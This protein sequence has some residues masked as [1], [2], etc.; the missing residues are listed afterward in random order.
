[1]KVLVTGA[2][3]FIGKALVSKLQREGHAVIAWV[4]DTEAAK[5]AL[6]AEVELVSGAELE[7]A[8]A[9]AGGVVNL[10]GEPI[11]GRWTA[12]KKARVTESR[13]ALTKRVAAATSGAQAGPQGGPQV[14]VS[15]SAVGYY[16]DRG[17]E[18]LTEESSPG[19]GFLT[20]VCVAW[21][22]AAKSVESRGVRLVRPRIGVVMGPGGGALD[23]MMTPF[24][25]GAGGR[26]GS[27]Q[28]FVPWVH[29]DDVLG[30]LVT[31]LTDERYRG[32]LNLAAPEP[33]RN[34]ELTEA[35]AKA[36]HRP[37][38]VPVP[39]FAIKVALGEA[40]TMVLGSTRATPARAMALGFQFAWTDLRVAL[41]AIV[42]AS[43]TAGAG[44]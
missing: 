30:L 9:R 29:L 44:G 21:E 3:G 20:D 27:G 19:T 43:A 40:A 13:V 23:K 25:L 31:A 7:P 1:M 35:L 32:P 38:V 10:A 42:S 6:G 39:A 41:S 28:Q 22:D 33:V 18:I 24:K 14:L 17:D 26:L 15:A 12:A 37:A 8:I 36:V 16:G 34:I 5:P 11:L 4:R 2:T